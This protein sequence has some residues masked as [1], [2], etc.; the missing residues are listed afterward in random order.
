[1]GILLA[2]DYD[3]KQF[4]EI[5]KNDKSIV[6]GIIFK[7]A[8]S[9]PENFIGQ[10]SWSLSDDSNDLFFNDQARGSAA[11]FHSRIWMESWFKTLGKC[12]KKSIRFATGKI[13]GQTII[14]IPLM[15]V[16]GRFV[17][18]VEFAGQTVSDYSVP[19]VHKHLEPHLS[20]ELLNAIIQQ[21][22][23]MFPQADCVDFRKVFLEQANLT[24]DVIQWQEDPEHTHLCALTGNW[25][26]DL[27]QFIGKSTSKKLRKKLRKLET[28]GTV[29]F[30]DVRDPSRRYCA[31]E[32]L[33][34][35]KAHQLK[36]LGAASVY[37]NPDFCRF[38]KAT[39]RDD[40]SGMVRLFSMNIDDE[41]IALI[42]ALCTQDYWFL[43]QMSYTPDEPGK[44][45]PGYQLLLHVM[46][47]ACRQNVKT[48]DFGWGNESYKRRFATQSKPLYNAFMPLTRKGRLAFQLCKSKRSAKNL[49][50][51]NRHLQ[52]AAKFGLRAIG[53]LQTKQSA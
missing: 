39:I 53:K 17:T 9:Q 2:A 16:P 29:T 7:L 47:T 1:M 34:E 28:F 32:K 6:S 51:S 5:S 35:W 33:I 18:C 23:G 20:Q 50:K 49:I 8:K 25:D 44:Y 31:G 27:S 11:C 14:A 3:L 43:Y 10:L 19:M 21:I 12:E 52:S 37:E 13:G 30:E 36:D 41:P 38:L 24:N 42:Y 26:H 45:S 46:E 48:F 22:A 4:E 15:I 40:D